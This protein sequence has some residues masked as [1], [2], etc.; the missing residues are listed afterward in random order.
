MLI[1]RGLA[2]VSE[3]VQSLMVDARKELDTTAR[4]KARDWTNRYA[5]GD[6]GGLT[7]Q[8]CIVS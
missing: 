8:A 2:V 5:R 4:I 6:S 3:I 1:S 7:S